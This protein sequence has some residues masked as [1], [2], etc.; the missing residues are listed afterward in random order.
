M[1]KNIKTKTKNNSNTKA[2]TSTST[3]TSVKSST[4]TK[5]RRRRKD[6]QKK[7][8]II[9]VVVVVIIIIFLLGLF[10]GNK[11]PLVGKW[12]TDKGTVYE[13]NKDKTGKLSIAIGEY[14]YKYEIKKDKVFVDFDGE[15]SI[16][17]EFT[18]KIENGSLILESSNGKFTFKKID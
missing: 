17:T 18:F 5:K 4:T 11:N 9:I 7:K 3:K 8:M 15:N 16:D 6:E 13:F 2:K 12:T 1:D 14:E 10:K